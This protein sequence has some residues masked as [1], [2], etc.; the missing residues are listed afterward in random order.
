MMEMEPD[1]YAKIILRPRLR[2]SDFGLGLH[3]SNNGSEINAII[4]AFDWIGMVHVL[5]GLVIRKKMPI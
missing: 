1:S 3:R 5:L 2:R 4:Q